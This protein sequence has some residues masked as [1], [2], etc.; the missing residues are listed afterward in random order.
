MSLYVIASVLP[1][2]VGLGFMVG[3]NDGMASVGYVTGP[4][5]I[6]FA[7]VINAF[8]EYGMPGGRK[9]ASNGFYIW[10]GFCFIVAI[11]RWAKEESA[12]V[13]EAAIR[14]AA[15]KPTGELTKADYEKVTILHL[16]YKQLTDVPKG[17]EKLT[18]LE[19]L[20]LDGNQLTNAKGLEKLTQLTYLNLGDNR[21]TD[22]SIL[23]GLTNLKKLYLGD[24]SALTK[25]QIYELKKALPKCLIVHPVLNH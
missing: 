10:L 2:C 8:S 13:I 18:Q 21:L 5:F 12:K 11:I 19:R 4:S 20:N 25:A 9:G 3:C 22:V 15:K 7:G 16:D 14:K 24:N 1:V 17:L 23:A 6:P